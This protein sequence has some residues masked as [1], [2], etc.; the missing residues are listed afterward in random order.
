MLY[1]SVAMLK[2]TEK[3]PA[4]AQQPWPSAGKQGREVGLVLGHEGLRPDNWQPGPLLSIS[5]ALMR[6]KG[7]QSDLRVLSPCC[8]LFCSGF[9]QGIS[10]RPPSLLETQPIQN[11]YSCLSHPLRSSSDLSGCPSIIPSGSE[12]GRSR[13]GR[14]RLGVW[15]AVHQGL[16]TQPG[17]GEVVFSPLPQHEMPE[18]QGWRVG[19]MYPQMGPQ[20]KHGITRN[21]I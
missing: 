1:C 20:L 15:Q 18:V 17:G 16:E 11:S 5:V 7:G 3:H 19:C 2:N 14:S 12:Q 13:R 8:L 21:R 10:E 4:W 9:P 6:P